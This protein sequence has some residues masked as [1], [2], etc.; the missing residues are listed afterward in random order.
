MACVLLIPHHVAAVG[1]NDLRSQ[2]TAL[3]SESY[4]ERS[5][6]YER[7]QEEIKAAPHTMQKT[8]QTYLD[9]ETKPEARERLKALVEYAEEQINLLP[10]NVSVFSKDSLRKKEWSAVS[11]TVTG[12]LAP[13]KIK[14]KEVEVNS[15]ADFGESLIFLRSNQAKNATHRL[16]MEFDVKVLKRT[17]K[18]GNLV[19]SG[20][21]MLLADDRKKAGL[22]FH[23]DKVV[24]FPSRESHPIEKANQWHHYR[25][26]AE[27]SQ[28]RIFLNGAK[29]PILS[30]AWPSDTQRSFKNMSCFGDTTSNAA[31]HSEW[32][33]VKV[34]VYKRNIMP[35]KPILEG[36]G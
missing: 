22:Y 35:K 20:I 21:G 30:V 28:M 15:M 19:G 4:K 25:I 31:G 6:A 29:K 1:K 13:H 7:I 18:Q 10:I 16:V 27:G 9:K 17:T 36:R 24:V 2:V 23:E 26:E 14:G 34:S 5:A 12:P 33:N 8:V 32:R 3:A 11:G